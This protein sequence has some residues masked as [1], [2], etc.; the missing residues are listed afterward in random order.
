MY[1][2][3]D[4]IMF[5][6]IFILCVGYGVYQLCFNRDA[7]VADGV[8][9]ASMP[10]Q[11]SVAKRSIQYNGYQ[12]IPQANYEITA[13]VLSKKNYNFDRSSDV[14]K[15][16]FALGWGRM[17]DS[18]VLER[19]NISQRNRFFYWRYQGD[20][21]LPRSEIIQSSANVHLIAANKNI[22][23]KID[24]VR[25]NNVVRIKGKLVNVRGE[26]FIWNTSLTRKDSGAGACE[27]LYVEA[28]SVQ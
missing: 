12:L 13:R 14:S 1:F 2:N 11:K 26:N 9:A 5:R 17:S 10:V 21:P 16:D 25:K 3:R 28:I 23:S 18:K 27:L 20:A 6:L 7:S 15:T 19:F 24:D 22:Q 8:L 4:K